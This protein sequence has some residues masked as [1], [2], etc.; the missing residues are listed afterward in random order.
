MN[1]QDLLKQ[2]AAAAEKSVDLTKPKE[3]AGGDYTPPKA[4]TARAIF[5]GYVE[6]GKQRSRNPQFGDREEAYLIFEI[7]GKNYPPV[8]GDDG[9][10]IPVYIAERVS[11]SNHASSLYIDAFNKLNYK[12][13]AKTFGEL[14]GTKCLVKIHHREYTRAD[15]TTGVVAQ[16]RAPVQRSTFDIQAPRTLDPTTDELVEV[17]IP[18]PIGGYKLF[19]WNFATKEMWDSI[20][21]PGDTPEVKDDSGKVI[22]PARSRNRYQN[23]IKDAVNFTGSP[24]HALLANVPSLGDEADAPEPVKEEDKSEPDVPEPVK[25]SVTRALPELDDTGFDINDEIPF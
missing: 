11:I 24:A 22:R 2:A 25:R 13:T 1:V 20:Y 19:L 17:P 21:I 9:K 8:Q 12:G 15:K 14:L 3:G 23:F 10:M 6:V 16:L 5:T 18:D 7:T 4:G